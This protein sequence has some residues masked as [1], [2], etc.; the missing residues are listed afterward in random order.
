MTKKILNLFVFILFNLSICQS[1]YSADRMSV[2]VSIAPQKYFVQ[3]ISKKRIDIRVMVPPGASPA[4]YEP[5][6]GQMAGLSNAS[7][8]FAIGVPFEDAWLK[9]IAAANPNMEVVHTHQG[10][11]KISMPSHHHH[12]QE[13]QNH[14][15]DEQHKE[16]EHDSSGLDPHIWLSPP[17]VKH[18][19][20]AILTALQKIDP[21]HQTLYA[22]NYQ[23][24]ISRI[25]ELDAE[26]KAGFAGKQGLQFMVFHPAWGYFAQ[27]YG[28]VQIPVEIEGKNPK[29]AQ[30]KELIEHAREKGIKVV[31]V[32]PQFSARSAALVA[33]EI[34]G[35]VAFADPLA[36]DWLT[37]LR[38]VAKK[39]KAA[40]K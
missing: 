5:K 30:L 20:N 1:A 9:K 17:L 10:I 12:D 39:F 3:Q 14:E 38:E 7:V 16:R 27:A 22:A 2:F 23:Q 13:A 11:E 33:R 6:P 36:A 35:Q 37:N 21:S 28:L 40:L 32:Q 15:S 24:F 18:Q 29:P 31:F 26:L 34:G 4:T 8:Y 25:D 19:A